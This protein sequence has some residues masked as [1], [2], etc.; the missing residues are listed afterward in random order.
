MSFNIIYTKQAESDLRDVYEY[1][2]LKLLRPETA[3]KQVK[4]I[5]D[6]IDSLDEMPLRYQLYKNDPWK[7]RGLRVLKVNNYLAFYLP[8]E[9]KKM[10][11][12]IRIMYDRRNVEQYF[13]N[14]EN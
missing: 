5:M 3:K 12:V 7:S 9:S 2:S 4:Q 8:V 10:V 1:I 14:L 11:V 6:A 13:D